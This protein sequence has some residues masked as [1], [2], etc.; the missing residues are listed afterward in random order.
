MVLFFGAEGDNMLIT[1]VM[2]VRLCFYVKVELIIFLIIIRFLMI[3]GRSRSKSITMTMSRAILRIYGSIEI[4]RR[5]K[6]DDNIFKFL[7]LILTL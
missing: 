3:F 1:V 7:L 4:Q 5:L 6:S 2:S